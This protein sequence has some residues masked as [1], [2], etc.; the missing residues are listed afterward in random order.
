MDY[1]SIPLI[2]LLL[3]LIISCKPQK[4]NPPGE[5]HTP[6]QVVESE[7]HR[8]IIDTLARDL[9]VPW[10]IDWLPD[11]RMLISERNTGQI[12]LFEPETGFQKAL[13]ALP[14]V[15]RKGDGGLL[16]LKVHPD[17]IQNEWIYL[18]YSTSRPDSSSTTVV[19]RIR[20][21]GD[22]LGERERLFTAFPYYRSESHYGCRLLL[23]DGFLFITI[24]D[25]YRRDSAQ[26]LST[27]NG[28]V[29]RLYED[30]SIPADNPFL[31]EPGAQPEIWSY[32]HRN[33]QGMAQHPIS[34]EIWIHEHGPKGGDEI[35]IVRP[36]RN[37]GWP[38]ITYGEEYEG[39][40][41]GKGL[42]SQAGMEQ[43]LY[44]YKPSIAPSD[45]LFY[46]GK[47][48]PEWRGDLFIGAMA[49]RHLNRLETQGNEIVHEERLLD[50]LDRIRSVSEGP[51][52][53]LY[54]GTDSGFLLCI[55]PARFFW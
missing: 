2:G 22:T 48:F 49:L 46:S 11:G 51:E 25:R 9:Q 7:Q 42:Q 29:L 35:N 32:G 5:V 31:S 53:F 19:E 24:G 43:P 40:P 13:P 10:S 4:D 27:H 20:L 26:Y 38:L 23:T 18:A 14:D 41:V 16:D 55:K 33:P 34:Q 28:K 52:G 1:R 8:F 30:G 36:G 47:A 21:S 45:M 39:G 37:Y 54:L 50:G 3:S 12:H 17:F 6:Q 44:Y 15:Y